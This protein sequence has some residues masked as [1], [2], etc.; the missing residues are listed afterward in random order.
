VKLQ[1]ID[2]AMAARIA[3]TPLRADADIRHDV[4]DHLGYDRD[5]L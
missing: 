1:L 4:V 2:S 3:P 5:D